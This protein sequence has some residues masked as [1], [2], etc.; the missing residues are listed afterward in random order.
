MYTWYCKLVQRDTRLPKEMRDQAFEKRQKLCC[1][2]SYPCVPKTCVRQHKWTTPTKGP[3][4]ALINK[5]EEKSY[6]Y[7]YYMNKAATTK[8]PRI[9][10]DGTNTGT[11]A[12]H[13]SVRQ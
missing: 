9:T 5:T 13:T 11:R 1:G 7:Y 12:H 6:Y 10:C 2:E 4:K 8:V 3:T